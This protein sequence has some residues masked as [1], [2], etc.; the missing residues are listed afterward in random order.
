M[1]NCQGLAS[2]RARLAGCEFVKERSVITR[3]LAILLLALMAAPAIAQQATPPI[4]SP[5]PLRPDDAFGEQVT[6]APRM[7]VYFR[8]HGTWDTAFETL[9]DAFASLR[10]YV[11]Q[12]G[13]KPSGNPLTVYTQT[14]DSGFRFL[15]ALPIAEEPKDPPKGDIAIGTTPSGRALKFTPR[16]SYES[17]DTT[18]EAIT[19]YLDDR[20]LEAQD[21]FIEEY[22]SGPLKAGDNDLVVEVYVPLK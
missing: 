1:V 6:L 2:A 22:A 10:D 5:S 8:G 17:M 11:D 12:Q 18:Y 14:D 19:N 7:I 20:Q 21:T 16:G 15:A 4:D 9:L 13:I 3:L